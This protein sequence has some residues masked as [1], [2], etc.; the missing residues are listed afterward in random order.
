MNPYLV[1]LQISSIIS[2]V[3]SGFVLLTFILFSDLR[4]KLFMQII[5]FISLSDFIGNLPYTTTYRPPDGDFLCSLEGFANLYFYPVSWLWT[6]M[7]AYFLYSLATVGKLPFSK[8]RIHIFCWGL[9]LMFTLLMLTTNP[10]GKESD[11]G[12]T[13]V[14][15]YGGNTESGFI[16]HLITYYCLWIVCVVSMGVMYWRI[17]S[18]R[19]SGTAANLPILKLA[20]ESLQLYPVI[21]FICWL[22]RVFTACIQFASLKF[23]GFRQLDLISDVFK[24]LHGLFAA[25]V[26]FAKS[27]EAR[28]KWV[29]LLTCKTSILWDTAS[30]RQ[31]SCASSSAHTDFSIEYEEEQQQEQGRPSSSS[32][33]SDDLVVSR[34]HSGDKHSTDGVDVDFSAAAANARDINRQLNNGD[35]SGRNTATRRESLEIDG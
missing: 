30:T 17:D 16:W 10:Y 24:I 11:W 27:R 18:I 6:T 21:M 15:T 22:P 34:M 28:L 1:S 7:L 35:N 13:T 3:A 12:N 14:C 23:V 8:P 29:S 26:F 19:A 33:L 25:L 31:A 4:K 5:T 32:S 2:V 9:P 20:M